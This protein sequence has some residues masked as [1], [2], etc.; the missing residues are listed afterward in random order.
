MAGKPENL[1][2][3]PPG[4]S[5]NPKGRPKGARSL[6]TIIRNLT[7]NP[8][9]WKLL[10]LKGKD[11]MA[12]RYK[13]KSA[14]EA[15]IFVAIGQAMAGDQQARDFLAKRGYGDKLDITSDDKP[16]SIL[17]GLGVSDDQ[18][19]EEDTGNQDGS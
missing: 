8:P 11:E 15:I 3:F 1:R 18:S 6:S 5:G 2:P 12:Q 9:D 19:A 13:N 7:E 14:W 10:P 17:G 16:I 4:V